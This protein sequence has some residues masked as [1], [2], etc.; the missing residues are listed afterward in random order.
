MLGDNTPD[1]ASS[2]DSLDPVTI[3]DSWIWVK[4]SDG[5]ASVTTTFVVI[6]FFVTTAAYVL[7][8]AEK[9]GPVSIRSFDVGACAAYLTPTMALYFGRRWS[10][11]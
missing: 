11:K 10:E 5:N 8:I 3:K 6:A 9:I 1:S 4:G 7:S 2:P